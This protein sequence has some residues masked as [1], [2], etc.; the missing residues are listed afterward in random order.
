[1]A[2]TGGVKFFKQSKNLLESGTSI[3]ASSG[4]PASDFAL[5]L[6]DFSFWR[7]VGSNDITQ[8]SLVLEFGSAITINR[9]LL[10]D[11]NW[12]KFNVKYDLAGVFTN[13]TGAVGLDGSLGTID[14]TTFADNT[15]YYEFDS[16]TTTKLQILVDTTQVVDEEKYLS[17]VISTEE[18][19]TLVGFPI[20]QSVIKSKN[21]R[22]KRVMS[23]RINIQGSI[24]IFRTTLNFNNYP[25]NLTADLDLMFTLFDSD[26]PFIVWLSGGR[27]GTEFFRYELR[28]FRLRDAKQVRIVND[29]NDRFNKNIYTGPVRLRANFEES[30]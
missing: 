25:P 23:G 14:E 30:V 8:E 24:E 5:D 16:V 12:K 21:V 1:M 7:S 20:V 2:I 15:A 22:K 29:F 13:F 18:L 11:I 3:T 28:G 10:L 27:R 4:Q 19:G 26:D 6:N 9:L 17:Q